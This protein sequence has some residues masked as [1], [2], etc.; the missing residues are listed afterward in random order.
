MFAV[1]AGLPAITHMITETSVLGFVLCL[2]AARRYL[3]IDVGELR[4][5]RKREGA[6]G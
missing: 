5:L 2:C 4:E 3:E 1:I 6:V